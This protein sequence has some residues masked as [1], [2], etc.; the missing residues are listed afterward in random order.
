MKRVL[1][2]LL[3]ILSIVM[4]MPFF[5]GCQDGFSEDSGKT[6]AQCA[7]EDAEKLEA[8]L[9]A[10][11]LTGGDTSIN[12]VTNDLNLPASGENGSTITWDAALFGGAD[13]SAI[14]APDG[15]VAR[16]SPETE[17]IEVT[18]IATIQKG[19][20]VSNRSPVFYFTV[21]AQLL[22]K[23]A[24][25]LPEATYDSA[26]AVTISAVPGA[27]IHYTTDG[28][29]PTVNSPVYSGAITVSRSGT[30]PTSKTI[31]AIAVSANNAIS[32]VASATYTIRGLL[33][34]PVFSR[35]GG[36]YNL[37]IMVDISAA[38]GATIHYTTDGTDPTTFS[39]VYS[40]SIAV[41]GFET[42]T[43]LKAIA[44][45]YDTFE[46]DI[47]SAVYNITGIGKEI[48]DSEGYTYRVWVI[49]ESGYNGSPCPN[50]EPGPSYHISYEVM[51]WDLVVLDPDGK[52]MYMMPPAHF[53][54]VYASS[55][56]YVNVI[57]GFDLSVDDGGA[58]IYVTLNLLT[59]PTYVCDP[60]YNPTE[61]P[62]QSTVQ[63]FIKQYDDGDKIYYYSYQG[64]YD[65][66]GQNTW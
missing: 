51:N 63:Q 49:H 40:G 32:D 17:D 47:T 5:I 35:P 11:F 58:N 4:I 26:I 12:E 53:Q 3:I 37:D 31:K 56:G 9:P 8:T 36:D 23:P 16:P 33:A 15:T 64:D 46:S 65:L 27:T 57:E 21:L 42:S 20:F 29:T 28:N 24:F 41:G 45:R 1:S 25:N 48:I 22:A 2:Y 62:A 38:T 34:K 60:H 61:V 10:A 66:G 6:D 13:G 14:I 59:Y 43:T 18:L 50:P 39:P 7:A 52:E 55:S 30:D 44:V 19:D 54:S